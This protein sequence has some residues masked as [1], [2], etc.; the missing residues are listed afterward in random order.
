MSHPDLRKGGGIRVSVSP[1]TTPDS[2]HGKVI[3]EEQSPEIAC[4]AGST[5][6]D[7]PNSSSRPAN[8]EAGQGMRDS[9]RSEG[10][11]NCFSQVR[12]N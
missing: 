7:F 3:G 12:K 9:F 5:E 11:G 4:L 10:T 8:Q 2:L 1:M 6:I